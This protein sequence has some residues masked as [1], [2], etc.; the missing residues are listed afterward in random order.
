MASGKHEIHGFGRHSAMAEELFAERL[1]RTLE[2][3]EDVSLCRGLG[4]SYGDSSLPTESSPKVVNTTFADR[5]LAFAPESGTLL[6]E[7]G[8]SLLRINQ[9]FLR[10]GYFPPVTP[11]TQ[12]V[13]LGGMVASDVHGKGHHVAGTFGEHVTRLKMRV[14]R[15]DVLWCS[16]TEEPELFWATIGG[17]GLTGHILEVEFLMSRIPSPWIKMETERIGNIDQFQEALGHAAR[18]SPYTMGWIDCASSGSKMG[19]GVLMSGRWAQPDEARKATPRV[20]AR[21]TFPFE[22]PSWAV[23][24]LTVS[25]FNELYFRM[26]PRGVHKSIVHPEKF[27]YP[28][29]TIREWNRLY[30]KRGFTQYQC[31]LPRSAGPGSARRFLEVLTSMPNGASFLCVIKDCG[32]QGKGLLSF[33]MEGISIACDIPVRDGTQELVDQLNQLVIHE[34]G[35]IYLA[36]D[37]FSSGE[38]FQAMEPRL[39][40]FQEVRHKWDPEGRLSSAQSQRLFSE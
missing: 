34:G 25:A 4:R 20:L 19:R 15:G 27:F 11:G 21:P 16:P 24:R 31:V 30:G 38:D 17:M 13:T 2:A 9:H 5:I 37:S 3:N 14:P 36:K 40:A 1:E 12:Y 18:S 33:P 32:K 7:A 35:R 29:D 26:H 28:L 22:L 23:N 8:L 10:R 39:E 6:A